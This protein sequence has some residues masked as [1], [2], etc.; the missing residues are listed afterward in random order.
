MSPFVGVWVVLMLLVVW[1][2]PD[3]FKLLHL[4]CRLL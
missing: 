4:V 3:V 1:K 2:L